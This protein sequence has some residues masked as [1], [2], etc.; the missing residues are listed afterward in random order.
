MWPKFLRRR[1]EYIVY[2]DGG[3]MVKVDRNLTPEEAQEIKDRYSCLF[4]S[5]NKNA[6]E[7][8]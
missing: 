2:Y 4:A 8:S 6:K 1:R 3:A 5:A 7:R